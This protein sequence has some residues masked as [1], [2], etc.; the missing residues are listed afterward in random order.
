[1]G[2]IDELKKI[3]LNPLIGPKDQEEALDGLARSLPNPKAFEAIAEIEK[4][5]L[6]DT[7]LHQR[8]LDFLTGKR[9]VRKHKS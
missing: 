1:M 7:R 4:N 9:K 2:K 3:V 5:I 8:A 6:L